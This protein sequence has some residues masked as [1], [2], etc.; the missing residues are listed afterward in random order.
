MYEYY[1]LIPNSRIMATNRINRL[2][3]QLQPADV[4]AITSFRQGVY[5]L[6]GSKA[7]ESKM[8]AF[9]E[10]TAAGVS[11]MSGPKPQNVM[12]LKNDDESKPFRYMSLV[13]YAG[14]ADRIKFADARRKILDG[15]T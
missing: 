13:S 8:M 9:F 3:Q 5:N 6:Y 4:A 11:A 12:L 2:T 1:P 14:D 7:D 15:G 10:K